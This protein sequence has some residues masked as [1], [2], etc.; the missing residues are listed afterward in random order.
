MKTVAVEIGVMPNSFTDEEFYAVLFDIMTRLN[1]TFPAN[2]LLVGAGAKPY[3]VNMI[4][5]KKPE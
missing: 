1:T 3:V 2:T 4:S 5:V